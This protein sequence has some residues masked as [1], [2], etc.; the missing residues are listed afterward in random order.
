MRDKYISSTITV[1]CISQEVILSIMPQALCWCVTDM[2]PY[3][4]RR[5]PT[6]YEALSTG[7]IQILNAFFLGDIIHNDNSIASVAT[8]W[9]LSRK[10][11]VSLSLQ[12]HEWQRSL[13]TRKA[14]ENRAV[15]VCICFNQNKSK[16]AAGDS[17]VAL[18]LHP[19]P[20]QKSRIWDE[21]TSMRAATAPM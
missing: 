3:Y 14:A 7:I 9:P 4:T 20:S 17:P 18:L 2:Q 19:P 5:T 6:G 12:L 11:L 16:P 15:A 10:T 21:I 8:G 1:K 13:Q